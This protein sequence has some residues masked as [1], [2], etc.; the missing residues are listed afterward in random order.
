MYI[1][2]TIISILRMHTE[3]QKSTLCI[4]GE[5][6][7][8]IDAVSTTEIHTSIQACGVSTVC[9]QIETQDTYKHTSMQCD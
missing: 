9:L 2:F 1:V 8:C 5:K 6:H 4:Y 3:T 7:K